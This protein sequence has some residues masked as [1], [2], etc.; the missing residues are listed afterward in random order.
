MKIVVFGLTITSAWGN[1]HATTFRSLLKALARRGHHVTFIEKDVEWYPE[2]S[3]PARAGF[4]QAGAVR[5]LAGELAGPAQRVCAGAD[6]IVVGSY[7]PDA[8][9]TTR[10][11]ADAGLGPLLFYD[12]DTPITLAALRAHGRTEYLEAELI[13]LFAA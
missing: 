2:Q 3:R 13:P 12:I 9:A 4:L 7:F 8:L 5:R 10:A 1:G 6:A 11:L